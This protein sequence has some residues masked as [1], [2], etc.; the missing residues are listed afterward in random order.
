MRSDMGNKYD[1]KVRTSIEI[2]LSFVA[3]FRFQA[4]FSSTRRKKNKLGI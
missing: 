3:W 2:K 4:P 1:H